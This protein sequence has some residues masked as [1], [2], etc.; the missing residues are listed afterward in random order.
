MF[1]VMGIHWWLVL[2]IHLVSSIPVF[3]IAYKSGH[4]SSWL[5]FVPIANFWLMCDKAD[6]SPWWMLVGLL[7]D[8]PML[9]LYTVL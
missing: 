5:A 4:E 1:L 7:G 6:L 3:M 9:L 2:L 8:I